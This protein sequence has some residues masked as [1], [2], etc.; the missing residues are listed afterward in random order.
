VIT[1][2][3]FGQHCRVNFQENSLLQTFSGL[4]SLSGSEITTD[5]T[6]CLYWSHIRSQGVLW[7]HL[8]PQGVEKIRR[9]LRGKFVSAP[10][11]TPS[12]PS[13]EEQE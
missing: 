11:I 9:N 6:I 12:A 2:G 3:Q 7:V 10:P 5:C 8:H 13:Q 4:V 1:L